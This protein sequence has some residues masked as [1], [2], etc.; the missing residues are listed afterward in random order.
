MSFTGR[1]ERRGGGAKLP[2][3]MTQL[4]DRFSGQNNFISELLRDE[5]QCIFRYSFRISVNF[6]SIR[7]RKRERDAQE[8]S[9]RGKC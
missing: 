9:K 3:F 4:M 8:W 2:I 5:N 7:G 6:I 1:E